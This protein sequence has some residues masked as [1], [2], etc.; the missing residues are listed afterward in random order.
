MGRPPRITRDQL[1][2]AARNGFGAHGFAATTL[3]DIAAQL[4][5]T[6][7]AILRHFESKEALFRAAMSPRAIV[8]PP[9]VDALAS[10]PGNA[11]P[12]AAGAFEAGEHRHQRGLAG[13]RRP[14][15]RNAFA[16]R[17]GKADAAQDFDRARAFAEREGDIA[18]INHDIGGRR[19]DIVQGDPLCPVGACFVCMGMPRALSKP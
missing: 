13:P 6:P 16:A 17:H 9:F 19:G 2:E 11:D 7:A 14:K 4:D 15:D 1:L 8:L 5:V 3:A 12:S 18:R 10:T